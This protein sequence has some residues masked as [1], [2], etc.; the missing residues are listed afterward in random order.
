M[1]VTHLFFTHIAHKDKKGLIKNVCKWLKPGAAFVDEEI[2]VPGDIDHFFRWGYTK[3][4]V[5][6]KQT[7][8]APYPSD[9]LLGQNLKQEHLVFLSSLISENLYEGMLGMLHYCP[10]GS[11][12]KY[13]QF[14]VY[15]K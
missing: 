8:L 1:I 15:L 14:S 4:E 7:L 2:I 3:L 12:S 6:Q 10:F 9:H 5:F 13:A 11:I